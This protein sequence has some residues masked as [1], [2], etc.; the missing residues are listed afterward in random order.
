[1]TDNN[2]KYL[3]NSDQFSSYSNVDG[4]RLVYPPSTSPIAMP[5]VQDLFILNNAIQDINELAKKPTVSKEEIEQIKEKAG[6]NTY[7]VSQRF[8]L[9]KQAN[10]WGQAAYE[11]N[12]MPFGDIVEQ[13]SSLTI[14]EIQNIYE[15]GKTYVGVGENSQ[16]VQ[17]AKFILEL[18]RGQIAREIGI[19]WAVSNIS[20]RNRTII[21][22]NRMKFNRN[23][24]IV[25]SDRAQR[26]NLFFGKQPAYSGFP[27]PPPG[28]ETPQFPAGKEELARVV[29]EDFESEGSSAS[30]NIWDNAIFTWGRGFAG[31][32]GALMAIL[33]KLYR[34]AQI[35]ELFRN[36][37]IHI[38]ANEKLVIL[39]PVKNETIIGG[40]NDSPVWNYIKSNH[41]LL[42]FFISLSEMKYMPFIYENSTKQQIR[43]QVINEQFNFII[44]NN[45]LFTIPQNQLAKWQADLGNDYK[46]FIAFVAHLFHWQPLYGQDLGNNVLKNQDGTYIN[47]SMK[48]LLLRFAEKAS[49]PSDTY[50][51]SVSN[52]DVPVF[53]SNLSKAKGG[54][55][56]FIL[57]EGH[58]LKWG[59]GIAKRKIFGD[60]RPDPKDPTK[61]RIPIPAD[62]AIPFGD[63]SEINP[64][65]PAVKFR[66]NTPQFQGA[67]V[68]FKPDLK[69]GYIIKR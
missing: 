57:D 15:G 26:E 54:I 65:H 62:G 4:I 48:E 45:P 25:L 16:I 68:Y 37:G 9:F 35:G 30:I 39:D 32:G 28:R 31:K 52:T 5:R 1:M 7:T 49:I 47:G 59:H 29:W 8:S 44:K 38:T 41:S 10:L 34:D 56:K 69:S 46:D 63:T 66:L 27:L 42:L 3:P 53:I 18:E 19:D 58:F 2:K 61:P 24:L 22:W 60:L 21:E 36:V 6:L 55:A 17:I 13:L 33:S 67:A 50:W 43:Q 20:L 64:Q 23:K 12:G 40:M 51:F 11:L 14:D